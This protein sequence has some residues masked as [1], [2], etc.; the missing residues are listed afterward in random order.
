MIHRID[1]SEVRRSV[2]MTVRNVLNRAVLERLTIAAGIVAGVATMAMAQ[3]GRGAAAPLEKTYWRAIELGATLVTSKDPK[4]EAHLILD[5][6][7]R[8]SGSDGCNRVTGSYQLKGGALTFGQLAGT[9]MAC[10]DTG[11]TERAFHAAL[12]NVK[13]YGIASNH[14]DLFDAA[15]KRLARFEARPADSAAQPPA[16]SAAAA[17]AGTSWQLV[18]FQGSDDKTLTPDDKSKYTIAFTAAGQLTARVDCNRGRGTW[19]SS[20]PS[21]LQ[22]GPLALTRAACPPGPLNDRMVK[23]FGFVRSYVIKNGHLFLS[24]MADGGIYEFEPMTGNRGDD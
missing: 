10:P 20:A 5:A 6:A 18:K 23:D 7:G 15:G 3:S 1:F 12:A 16:Q 24:L 21:Q 22:F 17:L 13:R 9:R 8:V 11:E 14:L 2:P 4:R 19:K